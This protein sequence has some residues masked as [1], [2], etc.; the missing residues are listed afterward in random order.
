MDGTRLAKLRKDLSLGMAVL[1]VYIV[2]NGSHCRSSE[3]AAVSTPVLGCCEVASQ[4]AR[5][6]LAQARNKHTPHP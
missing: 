4:L 5:F 3:R 6:N 1:S 2:D